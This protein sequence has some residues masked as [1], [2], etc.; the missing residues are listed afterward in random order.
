MSG[1][2]YD[3]AFLERLEPLLLHARTAVVGWN[4][5]LRISYWSQSATNLFGVDAKEMF[6]K[7]VEDSALVHPADRP[8]VVE[9]S[10]RLRD[11]NQRERVNINRNNRGD[12]RTIVCRWTRAAEQD[13]DTLSII[14][15]VE[16]ITREYAARD[17]ILESEARFR[18]LY[19]DNPD[20]ILIVDRDG[21]VTDVN[22]TARRIPEA[23]YLDAIGEHFHD[24]VP[25][26][27]RAQ[28]DVYFERARSGLT[29]E[30]EI[31]IFD[32]TG[33]ERFLSV[34]SVPLFENGAFAGV[35]SILHDETARRQEQ[36]ALATTERAR[37]ESARRLRSLFEANP[38]G[39]VALDRLGR[40]TEANAASARIVGYEVG[41]LIGRKFE[42]FLT[43]AYLSMA[44]RYFLT[45]I[46]GEGCSFA[47][48][49]FRSDGS[50]VP[51][52]ITLIPQYSGENIIGVY[53]I[54]QDITLRLDAQ[55]RAR[56]QAQRVRDLYAIASAVGEPLAGMV[57]AL[58]LGC[59]VFE[60]E[61]GIVV[62]TTGR[63]PTVE[64]SAN[65]SS[66]Q[67]ELDPEIAAI[68]QRIV[69]ARLDT[70]P[71][72]TP[73]AL[74]V[75]ID[76]AG[77]R[78]GA[79]V[80]TR[81]S[82]SRA[83]TDTDTEFLGLIA[84]L[85]QSFI[86]RSRVRIH[87]QRMAYVDVLTGLPNS[88]GFRDRLRTAIEAAPLR[89]QRVAVLFLGLDRFKDINE[90]LGHRLGDRLLQ[91]V[92]TR[93]EGLFSSLGSVARMGG[94]EFAIVVHDAGTNDRLRDLAEQI[95]ASVEEPFPVDDFEQFLS[96]SIG[97]AVYPEDG[98]DGDALI[99]NADIAM[100]RAKDRGRGG[101]YFY[102][103]TLESPIL[104]RLS[105]E[106]LLRR[107]LER[108]EFLVYYQ[109]QIDLT[110]GK[111]VGLEALVRWQHPGTGLIEPGHFIPSAEI[112]GLIV[113]LG[114][115]VLETATLQAGAWAKKFGP[116]R[117]AV[118]LSARQ[119]HHR[120]LRQEILGALDL[121]GLDPSLLELEITESV[122]MS[123]V[124]Q[125]IAIVR[126]IKGS[127]IR[128]AIDDFGTGYS[129][130]AYLRRFAFDVLK[131][132]GSFVDGIGREREDETIVKTLVG[133]AESLGLETVAE[134]VERKEQAVFLRDYGCRFA[135]GFLYAPAL[136]VSECEKFLFERRGG[137]PGTS[138]YAVL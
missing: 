1:T 39:V 132:D 30:Y 38:D 110:D 88:S 16:D 107:A 37:Y 97:I 96:A 137:T 23:A 10:A 2:T 13:D 33:M 72:I 93:I 68:A 40:I 129:S 9:R 81:I 8:A 66:E 58:R 83:F 71:V 100:S 134:C 62:D 45:A 57:E 105:Q 123:D 101:F 59:R 65:L 118:N 119:L 46:A 82:R 85:L 41:G 127:G 21:F 74:A 25:D 24:L 108:N 79:A 42:E 12:G 92:G 109:P 80:F 84:T 138:N 77:E 44:R 53:A 99:K 131:I 52:D 35:Y 19:A 43:N 121:S 49:C 136:S 70:S 17:S 50:I 94:D 4:R 76:V 126:E 87:L 7:T 32:K 122:A 60:A 56:L 103:A 102:N 106:R 3:A 51:L 64:A 116:L 11:G 36:E 128:T 135:Q 67:V 22:D 95:I 104:M 120:A 15:F 133:M 78:F 125:A 90:T 18:T 28:H 31:T 63:I 98:T 112:S 113:H 6:G 61:I 130:L 124:E 91:A 89:L 48:E 111:L 26:E 54:L 5:D 114:R 29:Q 14:S 115:W 47:L 34:K 86:E 20:P 69:G 75:P 73:E 27:Q 117:L 55:E